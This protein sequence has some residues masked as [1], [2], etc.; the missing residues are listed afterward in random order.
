MTFK[1]KAVGT[2]FL[3]IAIFSFL[4]TFL[5]LGVIQVSFTNSHEYCNEIQLDV[6]ALCPTKSNIANIINRG[7]RVMFYEINGDLNNN[8]NFLLGGE[9]VEYST[10]EFDKIKVVPYVKD[11]SDKLFSCVEETMEVSLLRT[12]GC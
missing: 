10:R 2:Y 5:I 1:K 4:I 6:Q 7:D 12:Q 3:I 9:S 8:N 11:D